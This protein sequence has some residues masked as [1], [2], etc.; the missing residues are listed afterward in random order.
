M[1]SCQW[2]NKYRTER[3]NLDFWLEYQLFCPVCMPHSGNWHEVIT[4][5]CV[6]K[7]GKYRQMALIGFGTQTT[8]L[9]L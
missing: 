9:G 3:P 7:D 6:Y 5:D 4:T 8:E 1:T 2:Q